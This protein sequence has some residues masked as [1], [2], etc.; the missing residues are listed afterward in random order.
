M[1]INGDSWC[2]MELPP[3]K[4]T[5]FQGIWPIEFDG[6]TLKIGDVPQTY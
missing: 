3:G 1:A 6:L 5:V 2:L 4:L